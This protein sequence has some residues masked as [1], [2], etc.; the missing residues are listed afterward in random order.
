MDSVKHFL[1]Q[2]S[3][4]QKA[5]KKPEDNRDIIPY[6]QP[7]SKMCHHVCH[8]KTNP[9]R[10]MKFFLQPLHLRY[11]VHR[12]AHIATKFRKEEPTLDLSTD[13]YTENAPSFAN[14]N[15]Q[16]ATIFKRQPNMSNSAILKPG[17]FWDVCSFLLGSSMGNFFE[18][19]FDP[20]NT[21]KSLSSHLGLG[22][23]YLIR[24]IVNLYSNS[25]QRIHDKMG[26]QLGFY[27]QSSDR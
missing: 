25:R 27:L 13:S 6:S 20:P 18:K 5:C 10:S 12:M 11:I 24:V 14:L 8:E 23:S 3:N 9:C 21:L 26:G 17:Y 7:I 22:L 19:I 4:P 1:W 15:R 2:T 16:A